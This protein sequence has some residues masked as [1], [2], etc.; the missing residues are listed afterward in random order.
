M[1]KIDSKIITV[2]LFFVTFFIVQFKLHHFLQNSLL[3]APKK[4]GF[5]F[6][7]TTTYHHNSKYIVTKYS[8]TALHIHTLFDIECS[9]NLLTFPT[10]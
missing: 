4:S 5:E 1:A 7:K 8:F 2:P 10:V 3:L 6:C 9:T